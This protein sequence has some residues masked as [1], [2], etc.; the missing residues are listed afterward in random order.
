MFS[1]YYRSAKTLTGLLPPLLYLYRLRVIKSTGGNLLNY[2]P[3]F[4]Y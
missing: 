2:R 3:I 4:M 1:G